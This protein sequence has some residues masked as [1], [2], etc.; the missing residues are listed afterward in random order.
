M[1][2]KIGF[3]IEKYKSINIAAK[4]SIWF[5]LCSIIQK[6]ISVITLP[7]FTR[8][9]TTEQYGTYSIYLSWYNIL[10][11]FITLNIQSEIFNKGLIDHQNNQEQFIAN[12][13]GLLI[14]LGL[15]WIAIYLPFQNFFNRILGLTIVL[16]LVMLLDIISNA[17]ITLWCAKKRFEFK[18]QSVIGVTIVLSILNPIIGIF[19]VFMSEHKAEVRVVSN[20][21]APLIMA[22]VIAFLLHKKG[23]FF[24]QFSWWKYSV[25]SS[26]PLIPHYLSLVVLNQSDKLMINRFTG[27]SNAAIYSVAH[28]AGLLMTIINS[29]INSSFVPWI[30]NKIKKDDYNGISKISNYLCLVVF[31]MNLLL[32]WMAPE[33]I[34]VLAAKEYYDAIWCLVPIAI[35]VYYYFMYTL[36]VDIE[37]YYGATQ[38]VAIASIIAALLNVV[39]NYI[40]IPIYG[41]YVAA[42]TT[43]ASYFATMI[44]HFIF[45]RIVLKKNK[46][47]NNVIFNFKMMNLLGIMLV[48]LS[49][50]A[51]F[52]Y[53]YTIIRIACIV[54]LLV[55][56]FCFRKEWIYLFVELKNK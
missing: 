46:N 17:I 35:S 31:W 56:A 34:K 4:A 55:L 36:F 47:Q 27:A 25:L 42:Y 15:F 3:L 21:I 44:L 11:I 13:T 53:K 45:M 29:S 26:L 52:L 7:I 9:M 38:Y 50:L 20:A 33:V 19:A 39:L 22:L 41:Y 48:I 37:I 28:S 40:L 23:K 30:Y 14:A 2:E 18:Y 51:M 5:A 6:G 32:I 24:S 10:V 54:V 8:L 43:L 1:S 12:Q 16:F 49:V